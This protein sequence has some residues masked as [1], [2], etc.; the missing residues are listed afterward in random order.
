M[1][2]E[3]GDFIKEFDLDILDKRKNHRSKYEYKYKCRKCSF[4]CREHYIKG[5]K[6]EENWVEEIQGC[7]C[8]NSYLCATGI[9]DLATT[10]EWMIP[11]FINKEDTLR[12]RSQSSKKVKMK[13]IYCGKEKD[14]KIIELYK[15]KRLPCECYDK[16]S[17]PNKFAYYMFMQLNEIL[18][19]YEREYSPKWAGRYHYDNY[20][21]YKNRKYILEMDGGLGHGN[22]QF[23]KNTKKD[24]EGLQRD[25][26]KDDLAKQ[27]GIY[28]IRVD[29]TISSKDYLKDNLVNSLCS[30]LNLEN[31][32][33]DL[34]NKKSY[35]NEIKNICEYYNKNLS[36]IKKYDLIRKMSEHFNIHETTV[37]RYLKIGTKFG[38][39]T[40]FSKREQKQN[41]VKLIS[42]IKRTHPE[43]TTEDISKIT[44]FDVHS[45]RI[46]LNEGSK[47]GLCEYNGQ[48]ELS[49]SKKTITYVYNKK[50]MKLLKTYDSVIQ[51]VE[52]SMKDFGVQFTTKGVS[53]VCSKHKGF[54]SHKGY[55][56]SHEL[57]ETN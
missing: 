7:G 39:T 2:Y 27:H 3:I 49:N 34:V 6:K 32:N 33:W 43:Y 52:K 25:K 54:N 37:K 38:W 42:Q 28:V 35:S 31:I 30:I 23:G 50:T 57:L 47:L 5:N 44:H 26:L 17:F 13:C 48:Q 29:A 45:I 9:N 22:K 10:D 55:F 56:F 16:I 41:N 12:F 24:I 4:D 40:Y 46:Y 21:E 1:I 53:L 36:N 14:Y 20:F 51:C 8:C 18:D 11:Y 19:Y 15:N